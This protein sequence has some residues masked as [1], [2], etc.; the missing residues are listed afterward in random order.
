MRRLIALATAAL[1]VTALPAGSS[2]SVA[3]PGVTAGRREVALAS[4]LPK[5]QTRVAYNIS[6]RRSI[7][8][9]LPAMATR[10]VL[11]KYSCHREGEDIWCYGG[12]RIRKSLDVDEFFMNPTVNEARVSFVHKGKRHWVEWSDD[13]PGTPAVFP[14]VG[15]NGAGVDVLQVQWPIRA[16]GKLFGQRLKRSDGRGTIFTIT[17]A[18]ARISRPMRVGL[19]PS[20]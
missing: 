11:E 6:V 14:E 2:E 15:G 9:L 5:G 3:A 8:P 1:V 13:D 19:L 10:V 17:G 12:R 4:F 7:N 16:E 20:I 18:R